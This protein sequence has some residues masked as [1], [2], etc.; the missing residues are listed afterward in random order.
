MK[1]WAEAI[2]WT[3]AKLAPRIF[4]TAIHNIATGL[5]R[6]AIPARELSRVEGV[7][8]KVSRSMSKKLLSVSKLKVRWVLGLIQTRF[9]ST[10]RAE[11]TYGKVMN[12]FFSLGEVIDAVLV[13]V[14]LGKQLHQER[15]LQQLSALAVK[16]DDVCDQLC[17]CEDVKRVVLT[18]K[19]NA[20][21][22]QLTAEVLKMTWR[23]LEQRSYEIATGLAR[24]ASR[25]P[26][27]IAA[28]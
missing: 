2:F 21:A 1:D 16:M 6:G 26:P 20:V 7:L 5:M 27:R 11:A 19:K 15:H 17:P 28:T 25:V 18:W 3:D 23:L 9:G 13:G 4:F 22:G 8:T 12:G 14:T 24:G 10:R